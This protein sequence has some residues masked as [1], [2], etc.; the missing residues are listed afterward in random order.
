MN[1]ILRGI[2]TEGTYVNIEGNFKRFNRDVEYYAEM[3]EKGNIDN[4]ILGGKA[5]PPNND[6]KLLIYKNSK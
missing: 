3:D 5:I 6:L 1:K 4:I 2:L